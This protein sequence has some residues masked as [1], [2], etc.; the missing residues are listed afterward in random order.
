MAEQKS[1]NNIAGRSQQNTRYICKVKSL[2]SQI[3]VYFLPI[4][5]VPEQNGQ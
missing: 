2:P 5:P 4:H 1:K 3:I